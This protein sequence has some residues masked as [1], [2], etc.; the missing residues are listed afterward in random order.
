MDTYT[1]PGPDFKA[2][3]IKKRMNHREMTR[4]RTEWCRAQ[5]KKKQ[6]TK[7]AKVRSGNWNLKNK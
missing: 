5:N 7:V 6:S 4:L 3:E 1:M 2:K